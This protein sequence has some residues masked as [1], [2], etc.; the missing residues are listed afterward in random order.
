M[1]FAKMMPALLVSA[2][3][4]PCAGDVIMDMLSPFIDLAELAKEAAS[5][6]AA[7]NALAPVDDTYPLSSVE[8][9]ALLQLYHECRTPQASAMRTWC[10]GEDEGSHQDGEHGD[11]V[12][13]PRGVPT[14]PCTGR[15]LHANRSI[16]EDDAEFLWPWKGIRC[17]AFT[18]PTTVTH[19]YLPN[20]SLSCQLA[21]TD[22]SV[23]VSLEQLDLSRN[24]LHGPFPEWLGEMAMLR[25]L[26]LQGNQLTGDIPP[27]F[28]NNDALEQID[29]SSNQLTGNIPAHMSLWGREDP[30]DPDEDSVL[31][32]INVSNNLI[33][34]VLPAVSNLTALQHLDVHGNNFSGSIPDFPPKL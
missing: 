7:D 34:G 29:V 2:R 22:L 23:M 25:L 14:H 9:D 28:A 31:A 15:V 5:L 24:H 4:I 33:T 21:D 18:E 3:F 1:M 32:I 13:C 20:D 12:L 10:T 6:D 27:S 8:L 11:D 30:H 16:D 17:D 26:N 19:I